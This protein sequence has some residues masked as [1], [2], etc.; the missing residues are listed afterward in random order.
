MDSLLEEYI[1]RG[2]AFVS[3]EISVGVFVV[4]NWN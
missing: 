2:W 1:M 3:M 4:G